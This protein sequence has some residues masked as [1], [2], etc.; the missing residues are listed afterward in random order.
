MNSTFEGG[1]H[2]DVF[3]P[4]YGVAERG[5]CGQHGFAILPAPYRGPHLAKHALLKP[6]RHERPDAVSHFETAAPFADGEQQ[7][8]AITIRLA[9][10]P[11]P[12]NRTGDIVDG[13]PLKGGNSN[14]CNLDAGRLRDR[15][16]VIFQ[17]LP[18]RG[19]D[20][21]RKIAGAP[22]PLEGLPVHS[23]Y[24]EWAK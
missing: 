13:F 20:H 14:E 19:I 12:K 17:L 4:R 22:L 9:N 7:Q 3:R 24:G 15:A 21:T 11:A 2:A 18:A 10:F 8:G 16:A 1:F 23:L 6:A 5:R